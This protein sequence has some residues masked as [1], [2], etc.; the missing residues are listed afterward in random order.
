VILLLG[1]TSETAP[2]ADGLAGSGYRVLVSCATN[3]ALTTGCHRNIIRRNGALDAKSL[4]LLIKAERISLLVDATHP[5]ATGIRSSAY[6]AAKISGVP[7]LAYV[8]PEGHYHDKNIVRAGGHQIAARRAFA[9]SK[10]VLL[11]IGVKNIAPYSRESRRTGVPVVVRVLPEPSSIETCRLQG[12]SEEHIIGK[13]GPFSVEDNRETI[14]K[15][16]IGVLVTKESGRAGG[17]SQKIE[18]ARLENCMV[19][20]VE[21]PV[22][23]CGERTFYDIEI[24]IDYIVRAYPVDGEHEYFY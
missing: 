17:I 15:Y 3:M 4:A 20:L 18:A 1:G 24:L 12:I 5:Y 6:E 9:F 23:T 11:T 21:R 16:F 13:R 22:I 10:P 19:I 2:I 7:Y 8:R 14:R